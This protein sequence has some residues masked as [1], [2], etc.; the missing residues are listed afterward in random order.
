MEV[1][2]VVVVGNCIFGW[3]ENVECGYLDRIGEVK[4]MT[5]DSARRRGEVGSERMDVS[6]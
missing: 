1:M 2:K 6:E 4:R 3:Y 5:V